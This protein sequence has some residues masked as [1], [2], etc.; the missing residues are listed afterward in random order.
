M[1][2]KCL[3]AVLVIHSAAMV[4][5]ST[6]KQ[7]ATPMLDT[8]NPNL[9]VNMRL[10]A[11][12]MAWD[13]VQSSAS[14]RVKAREI[15]KSLVWSNKTPRPLR[16]RLADYLL[17]DQTP[18]GLADS[19]TF[20]I[21]R[22]PTE[23]DRSVVGMMAL[24]AARNGWRDA[25]PSLVRRLA[26]PVRAVPDDQRVEALAIE[27][28][29]PGQSIETI[30]F[31]MFLGQSDAYSEPGRS[32]GFADRVHADAWTV[33]SR[34]D[35]NGTIRRNLV[36]DASR[37]ATGPSGRVLEDLRA[38]ARDLGV[39]PSTAMELDWLGR[40]H[41]KDNT[42]K[43]DWWQRVS[44]IVAKL[45]DEQRQGLQLRHLEPLRITAEADAAMLRASRAGLYEMLA[46]RLENRPR[47]RRTAELDGSKGRF[48]ERLEDW[49]S[50]L[51][52][53]DLL[54]ILVIDDAVFTPSMADTMLQQAGLDRADRKTE[55]G[56]VLEAV[57][58]E[59]AR[60]EGVRAVLF[61]PR[62][63]DRVNNETF[64][65]SRDMLEYSDRSIAHYHLHVQKVK[66]YKFAGPSSGDYRYA[67]TSGRPCVVITSL[68]KNRL[69]VDYYQAGGATIDLGELRLDD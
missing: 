22:L 42:A 35:P 32:V 17:N 7:S 16:L 54:T 18:E 60:F 55:Y 2:I 65:A 27:K 15:F 69:G 39:M 63:R 21:L 13:K 53:G 47:N 61:P 3:L 68:S 49:Q 20:T 8:R 28:L 5:C 45:S 1:C 23:P 9:L 56:G 44:S 48:P 10:E 43:Q 58:S 24:A 66:N 31:N 34:F 41:D 51:V 46:S 25:A 12:E 33:L 26:E 52:W 37:P 14:D 62:A 38:G 59:S 4:G 11:A 19:R 29:Y 57:P 36:L 67:D 30:V 6:P 50:D 64:I 40:L